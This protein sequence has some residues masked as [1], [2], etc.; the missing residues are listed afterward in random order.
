MSLTR[1]KQRLKVSTPGLKHTVCEERIAATRAAADKKV[2]GFS[3]AMTE[4][5]NDSAAKI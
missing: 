4:I 3:A 5:K 1:Q 2:A